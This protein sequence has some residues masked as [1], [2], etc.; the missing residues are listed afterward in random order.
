MNS[1]QSN[2]FYDKN[3]TSK[4]QFEICFHFFIRIMEASVNITVIFNNYQHESHIQGIN[5]A[6]AAM[7]SK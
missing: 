7:L 3:S 6:H 2:Y 5:A 4:L 1:I